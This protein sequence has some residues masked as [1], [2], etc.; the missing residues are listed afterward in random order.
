M[1]SSSLASGS[2]SSRGE[3]LQE[4]CDRYRD[5]REDALRK[6]EDLRRQFKDADNTEDRLR[7]VYNI[8]RLGCCPQYDT[9]NVKWRQLSFS[10]F[11]LLTYVAKEGHKGQH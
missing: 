2:S 8:F 9:N 11:V 1:P 10:T 5:E 3:T 7:L 6:L 4:R